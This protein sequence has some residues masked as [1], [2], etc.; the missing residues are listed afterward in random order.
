MGTTL[1]AKTGD[2]LVA[3]NNSFLKSLDC[4]LKALAKT[5]LSWLGRLAAFKMQVLPH[6]LYLFRTLPIPLPNSYF[7]SLQTILNRYIWQGKKAR[8]AFSRLIKHRRAGGVGHVHIQD[9]YFATVLAQLRNWLTPESEQITLWTEIEQT[10]ITTGS[11]RDFLMTAH[12]K[13]S[14]DNK[15]SPTILVA[16]RAWTH[17]RNYPSWSGTQLPQKLPIS[18]VSHIIPDINLKPWMEK[19][20]HYI[21]D[22]IEDTSVKTFLILQ[23]EHRLPKTEQYKYLQVTQ[24][25]K[26][27]PNIIA[28]LPAKITQYYTQTLNKL[29]CIST[30]YIGLQE[31]SLCDKTQNMIALE[32]ELVQVYS[33]DQWAKA[34]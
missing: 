19:G 27:N 14:L 31:K 1:T 3:N 24:L 18:A 33:V 34:F 6:L 15:L 25:L 13:P 8:C 17:L 4:K 10:Q 32:N 11:L 30:L 5:E 23:K 2:L 22:I 7:N 26:S 16:I 20:I 21:E 29:K 9:D 28:T 12:L